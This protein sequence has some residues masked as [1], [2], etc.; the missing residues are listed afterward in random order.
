MCSMQGQKLEF[1]LGR[2]LYVV[3]RKPILYRKDEK[4]RG[5]QPIDDLKCWPEAYLD[6]LASHLPLL[7][8]LERV[9]FLYFNVS[10]SILALLKMQRVGDNSPCSSQPSMSVYALLM[11]TFLAVSAILA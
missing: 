5:R 10:V 9:C 6:S 4:V 11:S 7:Q 1:Q 8:H 2:V 3:L